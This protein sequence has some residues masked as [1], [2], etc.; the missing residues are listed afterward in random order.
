MEAVCDSLHRTT[1]RN[2]S[3]STSRWHAVSFLHERHRGLARRDRG[4]RSRQNDT[5]FVGLHC[6]S[7]LLSSKLI[8]AAIS[9]KADPPHQIS[10][11]P[12]I[13]LK[14]YEAFL[15]S[16]GSVRIYDH[17]RHYGLLTFGCSTAALFLVLQMVWQHRL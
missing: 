10:T 17:R 9:Q 12:T 4:G 15:F 11:L 5:T 7:R 16:M 2:R 14:S 13:K 3:C 1:F 8:E 6:Q